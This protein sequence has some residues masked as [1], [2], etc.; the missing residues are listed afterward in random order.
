[1]WL[2]KVP[3]QRKA[4]EPNPR[5]GRGQSTKEPDWWAVSTSHHHPGGD[6]G[7][8][9]DA[10]IGP[11][12]EENTL[13]GFPE[14]SWAPIMP[15]CFPEVCEETSQSPADSFLYNLWKIVGSRDFQSIWW[16]DDGNCIVIAEKLFRKEVLGRS[17]PLKIFET[18]SMRGFVLQLNLHG[19]CKMEGDSLISISIK[20]LQA[21]L[22][23]YNPFFKRDDPNLLSTFTRSAG[24]SRR[25]PAASPLGTKVKEEQPRKRRRHGQVAM[26]AVEENITQRYATTS[27]TPTE[28]WADTTTQ[29]G[30]APPKRHHSH[31]VSPAPAMA[32]PHRATPPAPNSPF[33]PAMEH[34]IFPPGWPNFAAVQVPGAGLP[35]FCNPWLV[36]GTLAP[37]PAVPMPGP[38]RRQAP[39][40]CYCPA[41]TY[42]PNTAAAPS[43]VGPQWGWE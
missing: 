7:A 21:L 14:E 25:A 3:E 26:G 22:F 38:P 17:G 42:G 10:A 35:I 24:E 40:C 5:K 34:P 27:S 8:A 37:A 30:P 20:E 19:F 23:Y 12:E 31:Q 16:G 6:T 18:T 4:E 43:G 11:L 1:V 32:S 9:W 13:Q 15:F 39:T 2:L 36:M 33:T 41:C 28:P 29:M